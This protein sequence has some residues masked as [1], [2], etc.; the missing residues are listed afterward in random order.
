VGVKG[1]SQVVL[2]DLPFIKRPPMVFALANVKPRESIH[3]FESDRKFTA[4][5][6]RA[7]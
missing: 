4:V 1:T 6:V 5:P 2:Q 3:E 7:D